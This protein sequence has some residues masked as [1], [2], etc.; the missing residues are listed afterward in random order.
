MGHLV[1]WAR[2]QEP[3]F[4]L[5]CV[6]D[7]KCHLPLHPMGLPGWQWGLP[8]LSVFTPSENI[9]KHPLGAEHEL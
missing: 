1:L 9:H 2:N 3:Q 5:R 7:I 6:Q 4:T 8:R